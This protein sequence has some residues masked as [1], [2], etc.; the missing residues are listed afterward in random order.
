MS[1]IRGTALVTG[2][3]PDQ[4]FGRERLFRAADAA[5]LDNRDRPGYEGKGRDLASISCDPRQ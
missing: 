4:V 3:Q 5:L 2:I 1:C